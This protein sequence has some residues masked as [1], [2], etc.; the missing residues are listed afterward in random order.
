[1][2]LFRINSWIFYA[3]LIFTCFANWDHLITDF[4]VHKANQLEKKYLVDLPYSNL[5]QLYVLRADSIHKHKEFTL[6]EESEYRSYTS[7]PAKYDFESALNRKLFDF[8]H[9]VDMSDWRSSRLLA[10]QTMQELNQMQVYKTITYINLM[11]HN[12]F[13]LEGLERF[14]SLRRLNLHDNF[15]T[16]LNGLQSLHQLEELDLSS[17]PIDDYSPIYKLTH[18]K[19]LTLPYQCKE[20]KKLQQL[21]PNT[22]IRQDA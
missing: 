11:S 9:Q 5:P 16:S 7:S 2:Y 12:L 14:P 17:N 4:N 8:V 20:T 13:S 18:L 19:S 6:E 1:M 3:L 10:N 21:L 22:T 15:L